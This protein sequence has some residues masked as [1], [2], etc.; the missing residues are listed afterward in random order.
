MAISQFDFQASTSGTSTSFAAP[1][2]SG[3]LDGDIAIVV[4]CKA[5]NAAPTAVPSGY[6][7][8]DTLPEGQTN[9]F[10]WWYGKV[11]AAS[12]S[13]AVHTF[14]W[15]S[16][17][18]QAARYVLRGVDP[19]QLL[20]FVKG[21]E[22]DL[23]RVSGPRFGPRI[24]DIDI[25]LYGDVTIDTPEL[26]IPHPRMAERPFVLVPLAEIAGDL[27]PPGGAA[28]FGALASAV[29]GHGD[30]IAVAGRLDTAS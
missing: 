27:L 20:A 23:G 2:P 18:A 25:L 8:L 1:L 4:I 21:V 7:A 17:T 5:S 11:L 22:R 6:T 16:T 9:N 10:T 29:R 24:V 30:V 26:T 3:I 28:S 15:A 13:G 19:A 12:D 14:S